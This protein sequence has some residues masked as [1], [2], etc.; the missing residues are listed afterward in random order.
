[1]GAGSMIVLI[2]VFEGSG[3]GWVGLGWLGWAMGGL[4]YLL[5]AGCDQ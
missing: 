1:M 3:Q 4:L 2:A 5:M